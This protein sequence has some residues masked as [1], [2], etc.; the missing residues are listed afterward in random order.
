MARFEK[1]DKIR[2]LIRDQ[3]VARLHRQGNPYPEHPTPEQKPFSRHKAQDT[4]DEFMFYED[5]YQT[6]LISDYLRSLQSR[7]LPGMPRA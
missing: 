2:Q 3:Q 7:R 1:N 5:K 4:Y 6:A